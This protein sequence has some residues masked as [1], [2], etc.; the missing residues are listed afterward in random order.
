MTNIAQSFPFL[1]SSL[2]MWALAAGLL[3]VLIHFINRRRY[4][5]VPWAAMNFLLAAN[6]RSRKRLRMEQLLL[7][8]TRMAAIILLGL[9]IARP[10][11]SAA[12]LGG[13][14]AGRVHRVL[15]LDN[16][17]TTLAKSEGE[18]TRF[19]SALR[20]ADD[21]LASLPEGDV[22]SLITTATP[23]EAVVEY[24]MGD[25]R[26]MR[27]TVRT[28]PAYYKP[29]EWGRALELARD[30]VRS[31][32]VASGNQ[33][34]CIVSDFRRADWTG[35]LD[36]NDGKAAISESVVATALR[37]LASDTSANTPGMQ[38]IRISDEGG[39]NVGISDFFMESTLLAPRLPARA[40]V[41][42]ANHTMSTQRGLSLLFRRG[43]QLLRRESVPDVAPGASAT[44]TASLEFAS[45]GTHLIDVELEGTRRDALEIDDTRYLS[46][47]VRESVAVLLVD[48]QPGLTPLSGQ[49]GYLA[50]ALQ[51]TAGLVPGSDDSQSPRV[52]EPSLVEAKVVGTVEL[53]GEVLADY[54]VV[55]LC[56]VARFSPRQWEQLHEFAARGGGVFVFGG[57]Q[58]IVDHYNEFGR[59]AGQALIPGL[60]APAIAHP[61]RPDAPG[62]FK[63]PERT[64]PIVNEFARFSDSG[65]F[66]ARVDRYLPIVPDAH[67]VETALRFSDGAPALVVGAHGLGH[68]AYFATSANMAWNNLPAKGDYVSLMLNVT[69]FLAPRRGAQRNLLAGQNLREPISAAQSGLPLRVATAN[70]MS[71]EPRLVA[72]EGV[73]YL[74]MGP[75]DVVGP[76]TISVGVEQR[77]GCVNVDGKALDIFVLDRAA[78]QAAVGSQITVSDART[79]DGSAPSRAR[80]TEIARWCF[81]A[82]G[83]LLATEMWM[84]MWFGVRY[85]PS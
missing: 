43:G 83:L 39:E 27:E 14:G 56:N 49:A 1:H 36:S 40:V 54:D 63:F 6:R 35:D 41:E 12:P 37:R 45:A 50:T 65:L 17:L 34:I 51:P 84:A 44:V 10:F 32:P 72:E 3:P 19:A 64:H 68:T 80:T 16:S 46:V 75:I 24:P 66:T 5:Q 38:L 28:M 20:A 78:L 74:S 15:I 77:S 71:H 48:G 42:V 2:A 62:G 9:A 11:V 61:T 79:G 53:G 13:L 22:V 52:A 85:K 18:Q 21:W 25:R 60:L 81:I 82:A 73:M 33:A 47:E 4:R 31:S 70:G 7:L 76:L 26:V 8:L 55:A 30:I 69:A 67:G 59:S 57:D 23:A 29:A 58:I